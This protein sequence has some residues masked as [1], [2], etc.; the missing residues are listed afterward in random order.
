MGQQALRRQNGCETEQQPT[1]RWIKIVMCV[2]A[3]PIGPRVAKVGESCNRDKRINRPKNQADSAVRQHAFQTRPKE[4]LRRSEM[5][6]IVSGRNVR[7][8]IS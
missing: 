6:Y 3:Q 2:Q 8:N 7:L 1:P 5:K 4:R